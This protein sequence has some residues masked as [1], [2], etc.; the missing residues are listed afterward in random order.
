MPVKS[1]LL[2]G[3]V[4]A[5]LGALP[6]AANAQLILSEVIVELKPG[7]AMREDVDMSNV[8]TD[9]LYVLAEPREIVAPGMPAETD[10]RDPDPEK[11]G[12]LV[13]PSRSILEPGQHKLLRVAVLGG[14]ADRERVYRV[15]VKPVV[16]E[17]T[18]SQ[19]GLKLLVGYDMLVLVR[20]SVAR[21]AVE[22]MR[23]GH[24]L[25]IR[26]RGNSSVEMFGG[27]QCDAASANCADLPSKRLYAGAEWRIPLPGS[28]PAKYNIKSVTGTAEQRF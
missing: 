16:G 4:A 14:A 13:S 18:S 21:V 12:L 6:A 25:V 24:D 27:K 3:A 9:R 5:A 8:S 17:V 1:L 2:R 15:T 11:L 23:E 20:P 28:G 7:A 26:N 22:G 19:S 10:R